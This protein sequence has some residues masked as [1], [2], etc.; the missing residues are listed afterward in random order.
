M[1]PVSGGCAC[2]LVWGR[3]ERIA[4]ILCRG[5]KHCLGLVFPFVWCTYSGDV[6]FG[7]GGVLRVHLSSSREYVV[8]NFG[9][10]QRAR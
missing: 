8:M 2:R 5:R 10:N 4:F 7:A 1:D 6:W 9:T 3:Q